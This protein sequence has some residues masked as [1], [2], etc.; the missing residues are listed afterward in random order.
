MRKENDAATASI[1]GTKRK[2]QRNESEDECS[3]LRPEMGVPPL[4]ERKGYQFAKEKKCACRQKIT[5]LSF[6]LRCQSGKK[7]SHTGEKKKRL[8]EEKA[9]VKMPGTA[10][11]SQFA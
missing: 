2:K 9:G 5:Q 4:V 11:A 10:K 8:L 7:G 6:R 3:P 1:H